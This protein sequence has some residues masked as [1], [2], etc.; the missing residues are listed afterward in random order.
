MTSM[1]G[2]AVPG[3]LLALVLCWALP[4]GAAPVKCPDGRASVGVELKAARQKLALSER[5]RD[6]VAHELEALKRS[7]T[8]NTRMLQDYATYLQRVQDLVDEN[9]RVVRKLEALCAPAGGP[10]AVGR[11]GTPGPP[12]G[13]A[14]AGAEVDEVTV[15]DRKLQ[16]SLASFDEML[17]QRLNAIQAE[18]AEKM[19]D[20]ARE[21]A[22]AAGRA[23]QEGGAAARSST[24]GG[25]GGDGKPG[26]RGQ[27]GS[28]AGKQGE[29]G[30]PGG[31]QGG[32]TGQG[33]RRGTAA[34]TAATG[35]G[36]TSS[37]A[38]R[39]P[40]QQ[41]KGRDTSATRG[42]TGSGG[43]AAASASNPEDDDIVARQLR[44]AAEQE[45]DPELKKKLWKEYEAYKKNT[46]P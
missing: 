20:L 29:N 24:S 23:R 6:R 30:T 45:T 26:S 37:G 5:T 7:G 17:L 3:L 1:L 33:G 32:N 46:R 19:R 36:Q 13:A 22:Q 8:A 18:S 39:A 38:G 31:Q 9:R 16:D 42:Q 44:E 14:A 43:T 28:R 34:G 15:L 12:P 35:Q 41:D 4:A 21:A 40:G 2:K 11:Q 10:A 25:T 27:Q